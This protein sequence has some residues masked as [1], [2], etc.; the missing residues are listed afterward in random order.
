VSWASRFFPRKDLGEVGEE[1]AFV[2]VE[3]VVV[4]PD[5]FESPIT[6]VRAAAIRWTLLDASPQEPRR[7]FLRP[8][9]RGWRG[10]SLLVRCNEH[11]LGIPL[12][13]V[14]YDSIYTDPQDGVPLDTPAAA[15][16]YGGMAHLGA[17]VLF[18][19]E[20]LVNHNQKLRVTGYVVRHPARGGYRAAPQ[21]FEA[22]LIATHSVVLQDA[23]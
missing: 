2:D 18:V 17:S 8:V 6:P 22:E 12:R 13:G 20:L 21:E 16:A 9:L 7:A 19:R 10:D 3:G 15:E 1:G 5:R 11:T 14:R 23:Y 4:S